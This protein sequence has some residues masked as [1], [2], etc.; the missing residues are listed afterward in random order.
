[1]QHTKKGL[2][3]FEI[4]LETQKISGQK[5]TTTELKNLRNIIKVKE[6]E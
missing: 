2:D 1:M 3:T 5:K 6:V 4:N